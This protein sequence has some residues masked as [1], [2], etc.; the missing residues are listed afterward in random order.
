MSDLAVTL[1][2]AFGSKPVRK[3]LLDLIEDLIDTNLEG[4]QADGI[5]DQIAAAQRAERIHEEIA[6]RIDELEAR[7]ADPLEQKL[8]LAFGKEAERIDREARG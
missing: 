1:A 7:P 4:L 6:R 5:E 8:M 2:Q 3:P